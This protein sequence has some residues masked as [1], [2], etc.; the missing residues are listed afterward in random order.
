MKQDRGGHEP[1]SAAKMGA[2]AMKRFLG[3][4]ALLVVMLSSAAQSAPVEDP[5]TGWTE[6][7]TEKQARTQASEKLLFREEIKISYY[8][9]GAYTH[10]IYPTMKVVTLYRTDKTCFD[11]QMPIHQIFVNPSGFLTVLVRAKAGVLGC[12]DLR[13]N[14]DPIEGTVGAFD[15][16][17]DT[18]QQ[19]EH[20][21]RLYV[22]D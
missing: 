13:I 11:T 4:A 2:G 14:I 22:R 3:G 10:V 8:K 18:K 20:S 12:P 7:V 19:A 9:T 21:M 16:N 5:F 1:V 17:V 6:P 15:Y